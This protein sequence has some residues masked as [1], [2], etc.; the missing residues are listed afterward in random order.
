MQPVSAACVNF[1]GVQRVALVMLKL[2]LP[3]LAC[4]HFDGLG[5]NAYAVT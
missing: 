2:P 1:D 3:G 4:N 5:D